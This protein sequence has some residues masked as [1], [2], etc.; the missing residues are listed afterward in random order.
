MKSFII[1]LCLCT[2]ALANDKSS[3]VAVTCHHWLGDYDQY[4]ITLVYDPNH[5]FEE[6]EVEEYLP[7][8]TFGT[9]RESARTKRIDSRTYEVEVHDESNY[10][11]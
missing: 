7:D 1:W 3:W 4:F 10:D 2:S 8:V 11:N 9:R 6:S 5:W